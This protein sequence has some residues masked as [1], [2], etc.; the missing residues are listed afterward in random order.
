M[1]SGKSSIL[2]LATPTYQ[3]KYILHCK[4]FDILGINQN[5]ADSLSAF[6]K[7]EVK[8]QLINYNGKI[9]VAGVYYT[10]QV[11]YEFYKKLGF[12]IYMVFLNVPRSEI[13]KRV[14]KRGSGNWNENTYK[15]NITQYCNFFK[16]FKANKKVLSNITEQELVENFNYL[17]NI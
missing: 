12:D 3:E 14:L 11:D 13:Y 15:T 16:K 17:A 5:G 6:K 8:K 1:A 7:E 4:E 2:K 9:V 10:K